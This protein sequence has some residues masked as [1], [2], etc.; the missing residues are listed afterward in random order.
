[1]GD[2]GPSERGEFDVVLMNV[3]MPEMDGF[4]ATAAIRDREK[5]TG[6][7]APIVAMTAH[8]M[9]G[10]RERCLA[11]GMDGYVSKPL[12]PMELFATIESLASAPLGRSAEMAG[13]TNPKAD[14]EP[15]LDEAR[16]LHCVDGDAELLQELIAIFQDECPR[17]QADIHDAIVRQDA[18][19]L[20][21]AAHTLRGAVTNFGATAAH[22]AAQRLETMGR[23]AQWAGAVETETALKS[24]LFRL[25]SALT[26]FQKRNGSVRIETLKSDHAT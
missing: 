25:Q 6:V 24:A 26:D 3:Q 7:H 8:A 13:A 9:K 20:R 10:D 21:I 18:T 23:D 2:E 5:T 22:D 16:A 15:A 14:T 1:M 19:Q 17:W 12:Q 4:E 11:A